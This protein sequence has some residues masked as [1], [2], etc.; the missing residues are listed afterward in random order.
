MVMLTMT[1]NMLE[2]CSQSVAKTV[3]KLSVTCTGQI[4]APTAISNDI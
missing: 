2:Q 1:D 3:L 4:H